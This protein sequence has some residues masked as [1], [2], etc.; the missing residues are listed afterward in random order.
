MVS[1]AMNKLKLYSWS[2]VVCCVNATSQEEH[3][4]GRW[5]IYIIGSRNLATVSKGK[6]RRSWMN[7]FQNQNLRLVTNHQQH[8]WEEMQA[9]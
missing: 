3:E 9:L 8:L 7:P 5:G 6:L 1:D 2:N 4:Y